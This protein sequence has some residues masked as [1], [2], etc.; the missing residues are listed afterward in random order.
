MEESIK[1]AVRETIKDFVDGRLFQEPQDISVCADGLE[2]LTYDYLIRRNRGLPEEYSEPTEIPYDPDEIAVF[3][4]SEDCDRQCRLEEGLIKTYPTQ[5]SIEHVCDTLTK[6]GYYISPNS[7]RTYSPN[8]DKSIYG[9]VSVAISMTYLNKEIDDT[10]KQN[11]DACGYF[12]STTFNRVDAHGHQCVVY[13][14]EPKFQINDAN[15]NNIRYLYHATTAN[16]AKKILTQGFCPS[17]RT[18]SG[19]KYDGRCYFFKVCD[20][21]LFSEYMKKAK[22]RNREGMYTFNDD[23]KAITVDVSKCPKVPFYSDHNFEDDGIAVFTY[24]NIPPSA[25]VSCEDF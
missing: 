11:F 14:F 1:N 10:L 13:Q 12:L 16:A 25:I 3:A 8:D 7:F 17:N 5:K 9:H 24:C 19:F 20:K 6:K 22:K 4:V 21:N 2:P 15:V 18:K 23:F